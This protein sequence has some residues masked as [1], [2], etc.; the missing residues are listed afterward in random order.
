V[1]LVAT[2]ATLFRRHTVKLVLLN[3]ESPNQGR[4]RLLRMIDDS[5]ISGVTLQ[6]RKPESVALMWRER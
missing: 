2:I 4:K 6:M 1:E 5:A 3:G